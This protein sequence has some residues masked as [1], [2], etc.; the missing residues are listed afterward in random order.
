M[1]SCLHRTVLTAIQLLDPCHTVWFLII[2]WFA[3]ITC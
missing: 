1:K 2:L 3:E